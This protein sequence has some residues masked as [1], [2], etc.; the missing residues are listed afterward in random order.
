MQSPVRHCRPGYLM[1]A[2]LKQA[3]TKAWIKKKQ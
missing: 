1:T 3:G 2:G